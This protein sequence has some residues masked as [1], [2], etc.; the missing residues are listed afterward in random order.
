VCPDLVP[1]WWTGAAAVAFSWLGLRSGIP[2]VFGDSHQ[3]VKS[4]FAS[5]LG[6]GAIVEIWSLSHW[7]YEGVAS[8]VTF[9]SV[10]S[11]LEMNLAYAN[12]WLFLAI[13]AAGWLSPIWIYVVSMVFSR[14]RATRPPPSKI[15]ASQQL[16]LGVD[17][18]ILALA[19]VLTCVFVGF[20]A[21][22]HDPPWL[23]GTDA[24]WIYNDTLRSGKRDC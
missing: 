4:L 5:L 23:V 1:F 24:Y 8:S 16:R 3:L 6:I 21:Y 10:G 18:L 13:F 17:D 19:I 22:F 9:G 2:F 11:D 7:L 14:L 15:R 12:S 20:Y